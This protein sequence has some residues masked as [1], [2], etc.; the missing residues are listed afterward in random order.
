MYDC[1]GSQAEIVPRFAIF[2]PLLEQLA[3]T[4]TDALVEGSLEDGLYVDTLAQMIAVHLA[5]WHSS[6]SGKFHQPSVKV[7]FG[8][9]MRR[10]TEF[11]E[12]NL[13]RDLRLEMMAREVGVSPLYLPR[14]F[15][16]SIG[17]SPHR[18][19][20]AR[21]VERARELLRDTELPI[22][23]VALSCG[24][25][26]QSHLSNW[27]LRIVGVPPGAYRKQTAR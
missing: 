25:S 22:V 1:D 10:L 7:V 27:F 21:R 13:D 15:K 17:Q 3:M 12:E 24:F 18:Y 14:V 5:R 9:K 16:E 26:S 2:D 4:I 6:R 23:D 8:S 11:V 19:V 20:L